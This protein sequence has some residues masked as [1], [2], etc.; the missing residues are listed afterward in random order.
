MTGFGPEGYSNGVS[1]AGR[2]AVTVLFHPAKFGLPAERSWRE[3]EIVLF[4]REP[5][6][7]ISHGDLVP[8]LH[9]QLNS[10]GLLQTTPSGLIQVRSSNPSL[11]IAAR[12]GIST[13]L[14]VAPGV[15]GDADVTLLTSKIYRSGA[16]V[17]A[18]LVE[19]RSG[20]LSRK[21][22]DSYRDLVVS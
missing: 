3:K 17:I 11:S 12:V 18:H 15:I 9:W 7:Q 8:A 2:E 13:T 22:F 20:K 5:I 16:D 19:G 1:S 6:W 14:N 4:G 21:A 10:T